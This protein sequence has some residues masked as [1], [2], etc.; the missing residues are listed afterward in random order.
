MIPINAHRPL[1][2]ALEGNPIKYA[3]KENHAFEETLCYERLRQKQ[4]EKKETWR[5]QLKGVKET[6]AMKQEQGAI[7]KKKGR[8]GVFHDQEF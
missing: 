1:D 6:T 2:L 3:S 4:T 5:K 8:E 7:K